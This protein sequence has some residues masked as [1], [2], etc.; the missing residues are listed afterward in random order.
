MS[1]SC[2]GGTSGG[3]GMAAALMLLL[4]LHTRTWI[5]RCDVSVKSSK[6]NNLAGKARE[7]GK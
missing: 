7:G 6:H 3:G 5:A 2:A 4:L 1:C